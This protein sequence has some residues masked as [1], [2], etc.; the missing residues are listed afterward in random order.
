MREATRASYPEQ[1]EVEELLRE[2]DKVIQG[3]DSGVAYNAV[4]NLLGKI[5]MHHSEPTLLLGA[6]VIGL[7]S[8]LLMND[9]ALPVIVAKVGGTKDDDKSIN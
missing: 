3:K 5:L 9:A 2:L 7:S 1:S 4:S 6:C 8:F